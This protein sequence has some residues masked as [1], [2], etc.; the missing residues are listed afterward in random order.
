MLGGHKLL[1][2]ER[3]ELDVDLIADLI[4]FAVFRLYA[5]GFLIGLRADVEFENGSVAVFGLALIIGVFFA[6]DVDN[7]CDAR[8]GSSVLFSYAAHDDEH[9]DKAYQA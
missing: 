7:R 3:V 2:F 9:A 4:G 1:G 6:F 5:C 8:L